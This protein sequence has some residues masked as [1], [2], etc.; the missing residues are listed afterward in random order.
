M[1]VRKLCAAE[2]SAGGGSAAAEAAVTTQAATTADAAP[3]AAVPGDEPAVPSKRE[4]VDFRREQRELSGLLKSLQASAGKTPA[5]ATKE[6]AKDAAPDVVTRAELQALR[7]ENAIGRAVGDLGISPAHRARVEKLWR[8]ETERPA[9]VA[10]WVRA[11]ADEFGMVPTKPAAAAAPPARTEPAAKLPPGTSNT[12]AP[13]ADARTA[14]PS[15]VT[16][17]EGH[18]WKQLTDV[19]KKQ[20]WESQKR[21]RLGNYNPFA[22]RKTNSK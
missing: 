5:A 4:W 22:A 11:T 3:V 7:D 18:A 17:I 6:A 15:D 14:L 12:G 2:D 19:E 9:D 13:G 10:A 1:L 16:L 8:A 20:R 21:E